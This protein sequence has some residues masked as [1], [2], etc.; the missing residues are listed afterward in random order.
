MKIF[1][2]T[3]VRLV[4]VFAVAIFL[5][6]FSS[7]RNANRRISKADVV[8]D[9]A[10]ELFL[11]PQAVNKLLIEKNSPSGTVA[12]E[13]LDLNKL[14]MAVNAHEM[15]EKSQVFVSVDGTLKA[16]VKQKTPV[17]RVFDETGSYY[18]DYDGHRMPLSKLHTARVPLV[19]GSLEV[20]D[21]AG[22]HQVFRVLHDDDFLK[23]NITSI[24]IKP[25][26]S[27]EMTNRNFD[28]VI[29]FGQAVNIERKFRNYKAFFQK[30]AKDSTIR[31]YKKI[32]LRFTQQVVCT[33]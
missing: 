12:K 3:N 6:A 22:L 10:S 28:Y 21:T 13:N 17:V 2:W 15:V 30:S 23:K 24:G 19:T 16:V 27:L 18:I 33:K 32:N 25:S 7:H 14:E 20:K 8:L 1:S 4:V 26:G 29:E 5:F 11:S 31:K 9:N